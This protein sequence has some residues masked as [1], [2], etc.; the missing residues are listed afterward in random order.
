[1]KPLLLLVLL[2]GTALAADQTYVGWVS[3]SGCALARAS[4]G[5]F[6]ATNPDCARQWV[7]QGKK[8]VLI[9]HEHKAV[10]AIDNPQLL[11]AHVGNKV[12]V[13]ASPVGQHR[14]HISKVISSEVSNPECERPKLKE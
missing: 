14:L 8:I 1:M 2:I 11:Q 7:K 4:V 12:S 3:D 9:S 5:T 6:I 10:F 13:S